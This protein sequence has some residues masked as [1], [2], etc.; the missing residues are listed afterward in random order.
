MIL[1]TPANQWVIINYMKK[2]SQCVTINSLYS[3]M[4]NNIHSG[5][6]S[7]HYILLPINRAVSYIWNGYTRAI[8]DKTC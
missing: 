7:D 8:Y 6:K 3:S 2:A 5:H 4:V 1:D